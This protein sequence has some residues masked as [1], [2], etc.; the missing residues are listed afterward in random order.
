MQASFLY[1]FTQT[2]Q[3]PFNF[4]W[5]LGYIKKGLI[6]KGVLRKNLVDSCRI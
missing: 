2:V 4:G 3:K 6:I 1:I 5:N